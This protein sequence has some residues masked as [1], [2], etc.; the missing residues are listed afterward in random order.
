MGDQLGHCGTGGH[1]G[2]GQP[3][4]FDQNSSRDFEKP[5]NKD[6]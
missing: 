6:C 4:G 3:R 5:E 2:G 1:A